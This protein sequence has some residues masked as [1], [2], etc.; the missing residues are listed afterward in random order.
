MRL[1]HVEKDGAKVRHLEKLEEF[2]QCVL[3]QQIAGQFAYLSTCISS[4]V[5]IQKYDLFI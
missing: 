5:A 2:Q 1:N 3:Q 4:H